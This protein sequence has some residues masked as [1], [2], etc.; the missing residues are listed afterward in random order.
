[1][2]TIFIVDDNET[3]LLVAKSALDST[4]RAFALPSAARMFKL[5]EKITPDLILLDI[6]MPEMDGFETMKVLKENPKLKSIPVIFLTMKI[7]SK[8]ETEGFELGAVD[9]INKPF[10][11][12]VLLKRIESHIETDKLI[13][14]AQK[15]LLKVHNATLKVIANIIDRRDK[16]TGSHSARVQD[17]MKILMDELVRSE[18]YADEIT[19]WDTELVVLSGQ[20]HDVGKICVSDVVLIKPSRLSEEEFARIK[21]H[22][23]EG[24]SIIDDIMKEADDDIFLTHAKKFA[25]SH[26]EKWNGSGYPNGLKG[27]EIPLHGRIM[28]VADVYDALVSER[29]YKLPFTHEEAVEIIKNDSGTHFDPKIVEAF[30]KVADDFREK[31][32]SL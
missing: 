6:E 11:P 14:N 16:V 20:L 7:D 10:S 23:D 25:G 9:F 3:N 18:T 27:E 29:P 15:A 24:V 17:Y 21:Q 26:H 8:T 32:R 28:A 1:M 31:A 4:Y 2:K 12:P 22:C 30:L 19:D 13:K 5:A